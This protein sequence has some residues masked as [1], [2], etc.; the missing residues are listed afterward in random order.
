MERW[1]ISHVGPRWQLLLLTFTYLQ[2]TPRLL[3]IHMH[4]IAC[5]RVLGMQRLLGALISTSALWRKTSEAHYSPRQALRKL[6][7]HLLG[8]LTG[9]VISG[10][11][12]L[13]AAVAWEPIVLMFALETSGCISMNVPLNFSVYLRLGQIPASWESYVADLP[14]IDETDFPELLPL[15][16]RLRKKSMVC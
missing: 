8:L 10:Y 6:K 15:V 14:I 11:L 1:H 5:Y 7:M 4:H 12:E 9:V 2:F 16:R 3:P 13:V